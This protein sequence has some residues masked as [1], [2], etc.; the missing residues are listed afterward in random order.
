[1]IRALALALALAGCN[2]P[3]PTCSMPRDDG[4][5]YASGSGH[6]AEAAIARRREVQEAAAERLWRW[7]V[8]RALEE[9]E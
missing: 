1:M 6:R 3:P 2:L 9:D 8:L 7:R 4:P 5:H